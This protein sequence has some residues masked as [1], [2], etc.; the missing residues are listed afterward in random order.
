MALYAIGDVQGCDAELEA[1]LKAIGFSTDRDQLWFVGDLV[2]RG[3]ASLRVLRRVRALGDA[4]TVTLGNHDL[5]LLAVAHGCAR[6]RRD[7]TL[8]D[9][10]AA[11]DRDRCSIGSCGARFC[12]RIPRSICACCTR[13]CRP[14]GTCR[15]RAPA[16]ASSSAP[17][18]STLRGCSSRCTATSRI[19]GRM[20]K[21]ARSG[22]GSSSIASRGCAIWTRAAGWR[23]APRM[24]RERRAAIR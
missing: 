9:V 20:F 1:L 13:V 6:L 17:C 21:A 19:T 11:P 22:C 10:L 2:N 8:T 7:D 16:R 3:P 12:T 4:A 15:R 24:R 5:H 18:S 23:C 14:S